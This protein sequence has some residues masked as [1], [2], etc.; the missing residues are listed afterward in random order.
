M[1]LALGSPGAFAA[2]AP[3]P[4]KLKIIMVDAEGGAATLIATPAGQGVLIDTGWPGHATLRSGW[5]SPPVPGRDAARIQA[6]MQSVGLKKLDYV[7]ITHFHID[8]VGGVP[9]LAALVPIGEFLDH[10]LLPTPRPRD[11][12]RA[13]YEAYLK[14]S[15]GRRRRAKLGEVLPLK[16]LPG[17]PPLSLTILGVA[18]K[19]WSRPGA[20]ANPRCATAERHAYDPS[21]NANSVVSVLQYGAFRYFDGGDLTWNVETNLVCPKDNVGPVSVYQV[22]QHGYDISSPPVL[23]ATLRPQAALEDNGAHKGGEAGP[24]HRLLAVL[25]R[26]DIYQTH[27]NLDTSAENDNTVAENIANPGTTDPGFGFRVVVATDGRSFRIIN[28]RTGRAKE[29]QTRN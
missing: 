16:N 15:A 24:Y 4:H 6:A 25:P 29:Y 8:H 9:A 26:T 27:L 28:E 13:P 1:V 18:R 22:D 19:T 10:G 14:V 7:I 23:L 2:H 21:D 3:A 11:V 5:N 17:Q 20:P 12:S